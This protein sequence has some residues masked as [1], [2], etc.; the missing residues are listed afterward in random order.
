MARKIKPTNRQI[1][2][3]FDEAEDDFGDKSTSF[4]VHIVIDR[5]GVEYSDVIDALAW[6]ASLPAPPAV[7]KE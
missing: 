5:L 6:Q 7:A 3:A 2:D 1:V 4:L